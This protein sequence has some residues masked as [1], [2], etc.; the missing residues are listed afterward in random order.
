MRIVNR[1]GLWWSTEVIN[2][3]PAAYGAYTFTLAS[4]VDTLDPSVVAGLFTWDDLGEAPAYGEVDVEF[5]RW[6]D[7]LTANNAQFVV[8]PWDL[9]GHRHQFPMQLQGDLS[10]HRFI[11]QPTSVQF[12]SYQGLASPPAPGDLIE[13]WLFSGSDVPPPGRGNVRINFW[14]YQSLPPT[15]GQPVELIVKS[16]SFAPASR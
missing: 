14:L 12:D 8:Q 1:N 10:T 15:N 3:A 5:S 6:G 11:W 16:V 9:A 4:R 7:P 13:S 2:T